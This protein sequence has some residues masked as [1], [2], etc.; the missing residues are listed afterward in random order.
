MFERIR[1]WWSGQ[2]EQTEAEFQSKLE[3]LRRQSPAPEFWLF[4]KTQSGKTS[5]VRFLTGTADAEIGTGFQ[6]C[7]RFSRHYDFP[8][9]QTPLLRFLDTRGVD[10]PGYE[11][12]EDLARH[13]ATAHVVL[14]TVKALDHAQENVHKHLRAIRD[15][16]PQRPVVLVLTCLHEAYP[17]RQHDDECPFTSQKISMP[18]TIP[19]TPAHLADLLRS[20]NVQRERFSDVADFVVAVDLTRQEDGFTEPNYG[21]VVLR[22]LLLKI[23]PEAQAQTLR[24][25]EAGLADLRELHARKVLPAILGHSLLAASAGAIPVPFVSL[26]LLPGIQRRM[27]ETIANEYGR[28]LSAD[29]FV[30]MA[31]RLGIGQLRRQAVRELLKLVPYVGM[32]AAAA[33]AGAATY[34]LG[35]AYCHYDAE[36]LAGHVPDPEEM[37]RYYT[38]QM[39]EARQVWA[40]RKSSVRAPEA[41]RPS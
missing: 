30:E 1:S 14:V 27:I 10:E 25:V 9:S 17:Q 36:Q 13:A 38:S 32:V 7:T 16:Q 26:L 22:D 34:A 24:V 18:V 5:L 4:G 31:N 41:G 15:A 23:L 12:A 2:R 21:G 20:L 33:S 35:K 29:Q 19:D 40:A 11:P 6:P 8:D 37:H 39:E 28:P 3:D